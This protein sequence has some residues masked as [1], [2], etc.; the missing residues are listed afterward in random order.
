MSRR[1]VKRVRWVRRVRR[2]VKTGS[3]SNGSS[4]AGEGKAGARG[5]KKE[6]K[7]MRGK[8]FK[9]TSFRLRLLESD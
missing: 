9:A 4:R 1:E 7:V 5:L 6:R 3:S 8:G 2:W